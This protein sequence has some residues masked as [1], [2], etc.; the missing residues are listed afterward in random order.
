MEDGA[1]RIEQPC[2]VI[3]DHPFVEPVGG[4][5]GPPTG[6][7]M[8]CRRAGDYHGQRVCAATAA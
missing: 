3:S 8:T 2:A 1:P 7:L 6:S 5:A 4:P